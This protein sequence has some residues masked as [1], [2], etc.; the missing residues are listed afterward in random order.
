MVIGIDTYRDSRSRS[1]QMIGFV[2]S[3]NPTC[4]RY[5]SRVIEQRSNSELV[6]GLKS[7]MKGKRIRFLY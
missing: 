1:S 7:C 3:I 2:A 6:S 5:Y 4:T